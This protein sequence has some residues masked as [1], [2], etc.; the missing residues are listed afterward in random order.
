M[1]DHLFICPN[2]SKNLVID[3]KEASKTIKCPNC[4]TPIVAPND[5]NNGDH[6]LTIYAKIGII[7]L[8]IWVSFAGYSF[9][10]SKNG[11]LKASVNSSLR[12]SEVMSQISSVTQSSPTVTLIVAN[13]RD[14]EEVSAAMLKAN[15]SGNLQTA[16][17]ILD[18]SLERFPKAKNRTE[19]LQLRETF[20]QKW[21]QN[22]QSD[23]A[24]Q[25][26]L[27]NLKSNTQDRATVNPDELV[28]RGVK[29]SDS[30]RNVEA[31]SLFKQAADTGSSL[32]QYNLGSCYMDGVGVKQNASKAV[33]WYSLAARGGL[34]VAQTKLGL[35]Y[36]RGVGVEQNKWQ[37][38]N[39]FQLAAKQGYSDGITCHNELLK[40]LN[41]P[42]EENAKAKQALR[43]NGLN[44]DDLEGN[45]RILKQRVEA[46]GMH[47][48][49]D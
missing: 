38:L 25:V 7:I 33:F 13:D 18:E 4:Q 10:K 19:A 23:P 27:A 5:N 41:K 6:G 48:S 8:V 21:L 35:C 16:I 20:R 9:F 22:F 14:A 42:W 15:A 40:E 39:W 2:C 31:F 47:W 45:M 1:T 17:T 26:L 3:D 32:G 43:D 12:S 30:G 29:L 37:A 34:A 49:G 44:P 28:E 11:E 46:A 36:Y 24:A